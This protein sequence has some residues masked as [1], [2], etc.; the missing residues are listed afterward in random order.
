MG[1][2]HPA[3]MHGGQI[4]YFIAGEESELPELAE[5]YFSERLVLLPG[6]GMIPVWPT[7][8]VDKQPRTDTER[9]LV[10]CP[11]TLIKMNAG[12]IG[13]LREIIDESSRPVC[14]RFFTDLD[15]TDQWAQPVYQQDLVELLGE[16]NFEIHGLMGYR[17]FLKE[18]AKGDMSIVPFPFGGFN[19]VIDSLYVGLPTVAREGTHG[20]NRF[21]CAL[22]RKA[23]FE[24]LVTHDRQ[25]FKEKILQLIENSDYRSDVSSRIERADLNERVSANLDPAAFRRAIEYLTVNH[26]SLDVSQSRSPVYIK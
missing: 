21:P 9:V 18:M 26:Q 23:G 20:Y 17:K 14:F 19:T 22:L 8:P 15:H 13:L 25:E 2:G 11:W 16:E 10:N 1:Y 12:L 5:K 4:D 6:M 24:E 7:A 3:G